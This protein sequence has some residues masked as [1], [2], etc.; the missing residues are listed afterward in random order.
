MLT[1]R[2]FPSPDSDGVELFAEGGTARLTRLDAWS[3]R[4]IWADR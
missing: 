2:I 1:H 3:L 4:S